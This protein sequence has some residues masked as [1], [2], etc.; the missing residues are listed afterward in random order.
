MANLNNITTD[1]K[2]NNKICKYNKI[3][4]TIFV[5]IGYMTYLYLNYRTHQLDYSNPMKFFTLVNF[6][7]T[8]IHIYNIAVAKIECKDIKENTDFSIDLAAA[9]T[10]TQIIPSFLIITKVHELAV[11]FAYIGYNLIDEDNQKYFSTNLRSPMK[12]LRKNAQYYKENFIRLAVEF[13]EKEIMRKIAEAKEMSDITLKFIEETSST[14]SCV[15]NYLLDIF[16]A[17]EE[18][19]DQEVDIVGKIE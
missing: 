12:W 17:N 2:E 15:K 3:P 9:I 18:T 8:P 11:F 13:N 6:L 10:I 7:T 14:L 5:N 4:D 19:I 1:A 16:Y